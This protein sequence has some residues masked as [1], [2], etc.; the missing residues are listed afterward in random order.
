MF[1]P[2]ALGQP[3]NASAYT[4][5]GKET[6]MQTPLHFILQFDMKSPYN[7]AY[8]NAAEA[9]SCSLSAGE[10]AG[11]TPC[12]TIVL[13][14][15]DEAIQRHRMTGLPV[16]AVSHDGNSSEELMGTPW[17][18][19][20]PEAL[21]RDFL[22]KVYCRHYERPMWILETERCR[23]RELSAED[24]DALL[25]LQ[26]EN[27]QNPEGCFFPDGCD[28]PEDLLSNYI[29]HQYPF[30][31]FGLYAVLE[32]STGNFMGIAGFTGITEIAADD[33]SLSAEVSYALL[34]K[35]QRREFAKEVLLA[36]LAY[37]R[38]TGGFEQFTARIRP[39]NVASAA[40]A[41]KCGIQIYTI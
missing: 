31:D 39:D 9:L 27:V 33:I 13:C 40:L 38:K 12:T 15:T 23:L 20:S 18:I 24:F 17:L 10:A 19:L 16:I 26:T 34:Q 35:Y 25:L 5:P 28:N 8:R 21:T 7:R 4:P 36:L 30:F 2:S 41:R 29:R 11:K 22:Y 3:K 6:D 37:G 32:K 1:R 14:D